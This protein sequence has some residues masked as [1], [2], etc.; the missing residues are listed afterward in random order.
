LGGLNHY[1]GVPSRKEYLGDPVRPL[2]AGAFHQARRILFGCAALML[3]A[4]LVV[5]R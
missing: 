4:V 2:K 3:A 5:R 1:A